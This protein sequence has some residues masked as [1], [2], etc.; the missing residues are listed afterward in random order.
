MAQVVLEILGVSERRIERG[1]GMAKPVRR[2]HPQAIHFVGLA[3]FIAHAYQRVVEHG[4]EEGAYL[5]VRE[6]CATT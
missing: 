3:P 1:R 6:A 2:C 5:P 4:L